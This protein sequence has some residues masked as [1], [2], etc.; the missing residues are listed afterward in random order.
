MEILKIVGIGLITC[1]ASLILKQ[2]KQEISI[3]VGLCGGVII[4]LMTIDYLGQIIGTFQILISKTGLSLTLF[5][6]ILKIIGVGYL[7]EFTA[8][9]CTDSGMSGLGDKI[10]LAGK[11]L[12]FVMALPIISN[13]I[14]IIVGLLP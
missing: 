1:I 10:L 4:L 14:E 3:L 2:V 5:T 9:V 12:I 11:V 7:T 6:V 13:L 8:N